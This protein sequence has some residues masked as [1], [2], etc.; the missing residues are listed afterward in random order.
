MWCLAFLPQYYS[1]GYVPWWVCTFLATR[2][3]HCVIVL[4]LWFC[5]YGKINS[6]TTSYPYIYKV[7]KVKLFKKTIV[8]GKFTLLNSVGL[9]PLTSENLQ[10]MHIFI[11]TVMYPGKEGE[12]YAKTRIQLYDK[13]RVKSSLGLLPDKHLLTGTSKEIKLET[14]PY[15]RHR[16]SYTRGQWLAANRWWPC[17]IVVFLFPVSTKLVHKNL[18][19]KQ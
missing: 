8:Q 16:L 17:T 5:C 2:L 1:D 15:A 9:L 10:N 6:L 19:R 3:C 11:Q 13:L 4:Q 12:D 7:G 18:Q 14:V